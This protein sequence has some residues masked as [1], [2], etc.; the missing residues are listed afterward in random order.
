MSRYI[1]RI[2]CEKIGHD[3]PDRWHNHLLNVL[4]CHVGDNVFLF[5][6]NDGEWLCEITEITKRKICIS[7]RECTRQYQKPYKLCLGFC[8]IKLDKVKFIIEKCTELGVTD[9][10][11]LISS[12]TQVHD[13]PI[14]KLHLIAIQAVEQS[15]LLYIPSIFPTQKLDSFVENLNPNVIWYGG[16]ER[17]DHV[18]EIKP[19]NELGLIIGPEGG[20]SPEE[21]L[22]L[23]K[24]VNLLKLSNNILRSETAC[25]AGSALLSNSIS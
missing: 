19:N 6:M 10:Y 13:I 7:K 16:I 11:P 15:E 4:K 8:L 18:N 21:K 24:K 9:F 25:I 1:P 17:L 12:Y 3:I 22:L 20:F 5:N 23:Q 14:S 2:Y